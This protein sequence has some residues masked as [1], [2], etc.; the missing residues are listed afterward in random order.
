LIVSHDRAFLDKIVTKIIEIDIVTKFSSIYE[1][2]Y[3]SYAE[4][5]EAKID[6]QWKEYNDK[7]EK[8]E[9]FN[10]NIDQKSTWFLDIESVKKGKKRKEDYNNGKDVNY[11]NADGKAARRIKVMKN[12]LEKYKENSSDITKPKYDLPLQVVFENERGS[13]KVFDL[14]NLEKKMGKRKIGP[15]N[16]HIQYG[17]RLHL[18]GKNG[19]GKT[20]LLKMLVG[21]LKPDS[22]II[23]KGEN[24]KIGYISQERWL[25]RPNKKV[26][27]EFLETT[28]I[29]E[30]NARRLLNRFRITTE[31]VKKHVSLIS[32]G[33][34][35]RLII[36]ELVAIKPNCIILDE[37]SNHLD[38]EVIEELEN[39]LK[40]YK[41]TLIVVSHDRYF[42]E[43]IKLNQIFDLDVNSTKL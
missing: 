16:L 10:T 43:K 11:K 18:V 26:I 4:Q 22:G 2:N 25:N 12:R 21:E 42:V 1:G 8:T 15:I 29:S 32:P 33:E 35:S 30:S 6:R 36:A 3:S 27:E 9:K 5:R 34:Y 13:T 17:D 24:L 40:E 14:K 41:G 7:V 19:T 31:D 28:K 20:T 23:E 39:G 38:L 37:P